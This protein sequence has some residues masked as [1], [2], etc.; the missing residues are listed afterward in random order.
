VS[1]RSS[2][3]TGLLL[4][5]GGLAVFT[6]TFTAVF[7]GAAEGVVLVLTVGTCTPFTP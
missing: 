6:G 2:S 4:A 1:T 5:S 7:T 3:S